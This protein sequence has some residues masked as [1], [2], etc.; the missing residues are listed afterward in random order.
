MRM[1]RAVGEL[2]NENPFVASP[3]M[4]VER[5]TQELRARR[6]G[7]I[8]VVQ[9]GKLVG[10]VT[11]TDLLRAFAGDGPKVARPSAR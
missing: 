5:A 7:C 11:R 3:A 1:G 10:I 6:I 4:S 8:P 9:R 2:M